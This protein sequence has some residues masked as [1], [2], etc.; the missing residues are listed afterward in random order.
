MHIDPTLAAA[1]GTAFTV[2]MGGIGWLVKAMWADRV[3]LMEKFL[4]MLAQQY[5]DAAKRKELWEAQARVIEGQ[6]RTITDLT[7][8]IGHLRED[9][10][11]LKP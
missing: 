7:R 9:V 2:S 1:L 4:K 3:A 6:T 5:E 11:R 10:R 8:E